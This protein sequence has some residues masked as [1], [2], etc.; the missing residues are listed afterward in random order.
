MRGE[1]KEKKKKEKEKPL[2]KQW[3]PALL[4]CSVN[5]KSCDTETHEKV[6]KKFIYKFFHT[7]WQTAL[8]LFVGLDDYGSSIKK[9]KKK[10]C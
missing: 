3:K 7:S 6:K 4:V 9:K 8:F 5:D 10:T 1:K 2:G